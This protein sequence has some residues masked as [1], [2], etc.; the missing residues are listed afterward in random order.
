MTYTEWT[1]EQ[2]TKQTKVLNKL[3]DK[4][5]EEVVDYFVFENMVINEP[6]YCKLYEDNKKC[7]E[8][9]YLNCFNCGCPYF[10]FTEDPNGISQEDGIPIMSRCTIDSRAGRQ[11]KS[12]T[13]IHHDCTGCTIN[14]TK[15]HTLKQ[16]KVTNG[17]TN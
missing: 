11:F 2:S 5:I 16:L 15:Q 7:H 10:E 17:R 1:I 12:A 13:V 3:S 4:P 9:E 8:I 6:D 14:H